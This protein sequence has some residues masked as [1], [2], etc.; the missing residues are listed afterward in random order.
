VGVVVRRGDGRDITVK[1]NDDSG[2]SSDDV[3]LCL[4]RRQNEDTVEW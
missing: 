4:E 3:V 2:W 1:G